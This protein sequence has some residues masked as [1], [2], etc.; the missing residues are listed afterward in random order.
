MSAVKLRVTLLPPKAFGFGNGNALQ[1][2]IN[3]VVDVLS[4]DALGG[5]PG[6]GGRGKLKRVLLMVRV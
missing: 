4:S 2:W 1:R 6:G 5:T 3:S